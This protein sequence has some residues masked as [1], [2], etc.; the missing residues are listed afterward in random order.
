VNELNGKKM[1]IGVFD[2]KPEELEETAQAVRSGFERLKADAEVWTYDDSRAFIE[3]FRESRY[4]MIFMGVD[5]MMG[6]EAARMIRGFG[7]DCH[8]FF[9]SN[10]TEYGVEAFRLT[11]HDY[12]MKPLT[13]EKVEE[14][15]GRLRKKRGAAKD[16]PFALGSECY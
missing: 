13:A 2:L 14:V 9:V 5:S 10:S 6:V 3:G 16:S 7:P 4:D 8:M 12:L 1:K 15:A 11:C